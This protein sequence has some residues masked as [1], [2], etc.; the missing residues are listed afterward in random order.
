MG[1]GFFFVVW[2][3]FLLNCFL[4]QK[5][6]DIAA[7][8]CWMLVDDVVYVYITC[9]TRFNGQDTLPETNIVPENRPPQ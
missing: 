6:M 3:V 8:G 1:K 9:I 7:D 5:W 2:G 4:P